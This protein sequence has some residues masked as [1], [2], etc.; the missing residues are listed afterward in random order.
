[1]D[2]AS[3]HRA[4]GDGGHSKNTLRKIH[5][6]N[7]QLFTTDLILLIGVLHKFPFFG[8]PI[9]ER[10]ILG[11]DTLDM[12]TARFQHC[13]ALED[14]AVLAIGGNQSHLD[15][16]TVLGSRAFEK[17]RSHGYRRVGTAH[18]GKL[19]HLHRVQSDVCPCIARDGEKNLSVVIGEHIIRDKNLVGVL[20]LPVM[21]YARPGKLQVA[22]E[23]VDSLHSVC[24]DTGIG[25]S[26]GSEDMETVAFLRVKSGDG[27][28]AVV[29]RGFDEEIILGGRRH[30]HIAQQLG[31]RLKQTTSSTLPVCRETA[32]EGHGETCRQVVGIDKIAIYSTLGGI[33]VARLIVGD[34]VPVMAVAVNP[35]GDS[36]L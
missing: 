34:V 8:H 3:G 7:R 12:E 35:F 36:S 13:E 10:S 11:R 19:L 21:S 27:E 16:L 33:F 1:M 32:V 31:G 25:G 28:I 29:L 23:L 17:S 14:P 30:S 4:G 5:T 6:D 20:V 15:R 2:G 26:A 18:A 22:G 24:P 9:A